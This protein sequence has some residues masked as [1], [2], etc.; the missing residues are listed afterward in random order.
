MEG[1]DKRRL[2]GRVRLVL[3]VFAVG[4]LAVIARSAQLQIGQYDELSRLARGQYLN[5][6]Q[7]PARRGQIYDRNGEPLAISVDVPSVYANP[8]A[9]TDPRAAAKALAPILEITREQAYQKLTQDRLF[10]WLKRQV[11]PEVEAKIRGLGIAGIGMTKESRR[12]YPHR[13]LGSQIVGFTNVDAHGIEGVENAFDEVLAGEPQV[14][15]IERDGR[16]HA[17]LKSGLD[18]DQRTKGADVYLTIDLQI[19]HAVETALAKAL[20]AKRAHSAMAV[21]LDVERG[22][23]LALGTVPEFNPNLGADASAEVRR[24]RAI[25]DMFE[26]GSAFK[27]FVISAALDSGAIRPDLTLF[28]ENGSFAVADRTIHDSEPHGWLTLSGVIQKSSNICAAKIGETLGRE[29]LGRAVRDFGFGQRTGVSFPGEATGL[30]RDPATWSEVSVATIS[31]G[32]GVSV[33]ELQ[34]AAAYR[35]LADGG[36]YRPPRLVAAVRSPEGEKLEV[37][38]GPER[39]VVS[40]VTTEQV[41]AMLEAV[42]GPGGTGGLAAVPGFRVAGKTGTAQKPDLVAGGYTANAFMAVFAGYL[43]AQAPR[44]VIVVAI[45]DPAMQHTG[46]TVAAPVFAEIAAT[47]M[48]VLG[49][50]PT[51]VTAPSAAPTAD[52]VAR[53]RALEAP[54]R[55]G[56]PVRP[57][58]VPS[59]IGLTA[60]QAVHRFEEVGSGLELEL[61]GTGRVVRQEPA[62]G[63]DRARIERVTLV[64]AE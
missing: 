4:A 38:L 43:P 7:V 20:K 39:K 53:A 45:D 5:D 24:N 19:Q 16:G 57:G 28:C 58:A 54:I 50:A 64:M 44:A 51:E 15:G 32:H 34:L 21:V 59:F 6:V 26:P 2:V 41:R 25:A 12:F 33:T 22:D 3:V 8:G 29:R 17:V 40:R 18:P 47:T 10:V 52:V 56:P 14:V 60:R 11:S 37:P 48:R 30:V 61:L 46:G 36:R 42:V 13:E 63:T 1:R 31:F 49:V 55:E 23:I 62:V 35:V 9:V 27:P